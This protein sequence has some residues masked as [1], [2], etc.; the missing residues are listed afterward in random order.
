VAAVLAA[1]A[2]P[3]YATT[4]SWKGLTW[5]EYG[6]NTTAVVNGTGGLDITVLGGQ[7]L[8]PGTDN[9]VLHSSLPANL[10]Q[11]NAPW[12][13]FTF[14]DTYAGDAA[15]GGPRGYVDTDIYPSGNEL[16]TMWQGGVYAGHSH[17]YLNHNV[18]DKANGGWANDPNNWYTGPV[19]TAGEHTVKY[20][21]GPS[22]DV[23]M[24]F[25]GV[26]GQT[27]PASAGCTLFQSMYLGVQTTAGS[28]FTATYDDLT[29]GTG[30]VNAPEPS[31]FALLGIAGLG[32]LAYTRRRWQR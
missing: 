12:I 31:T 10:T 25:D 28:T 26:L 4:V 22:G 14:T 7:S 1:M 11:A 16:E 19:R 8:D 5:N 20:G 21:M 2:T 18:Y 13:Q 32:L 23:D 3:S 9:W 6:T 27:I 30:Y 15:V 29:W 24:W 17:D